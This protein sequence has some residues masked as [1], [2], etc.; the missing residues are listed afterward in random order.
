MGDIEEL[1]PGGE[2]DVHTKAVLIAGGGYVGLYAALRLQKA[3]RRDLA[4]GTVSI[5]VV[6]PRSYMTY[7]PFLPEAAAGNLEPRHVVVALRRLLP[8]VKVITGRIAAIDHASHTARIEPCAGTPYDVHYDELVVALGSVARTLPIPGLAEHAIGF[9]QVEEAIQLRNHVLDRLDIAESTTDERIRR[10]ALTFVFVGGGYAGVEAMAE[11]EDMARYATRYYERVKSSDMRWVLVEAADRIL[12]EV[13]ADLGRYTVDRLRERAIDVKLNTL[14]ESCVDGHVV[15]SDGSRFES[16]T[17]VWT[18]G[19]KANPVLAASD[20]PLDDKGRIRAAANLRVVG[21]PDVWAAGDA[22]AVPDLSGPEGALCSPSAQHAV[23]QAK[24]LG[25]NLVRALRGKPLRD[26]RHSH[27]GSVASLGLHKGVAQ[28]YGVKLKGWPAW[29]MH[30]TYHVSRMPTLNRKIR[31]ISDWT[32]ALFFRREI[33]SLGNLQR[34]REEFV[35]SAMPR[36]V[37]HTDAVEQGAV[38]LAAVERQA[39]KR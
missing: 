27:A 37:S 34:P 13:G 24:V 8:R 39:A 4:K 20:L 10:R 16:D 35:R 23:R 18:A 2:W 32:L 36:Q 5:T 31:I 22:A 7:Q 25:D 6:D 26:Y 28:V 1:S 30:R 15:L 11:L 12:P 19:V 29:F 3:L 17:L 33:V 21:L 9:K 38:E 14:L